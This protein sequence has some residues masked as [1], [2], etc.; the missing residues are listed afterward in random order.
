MPLA[1]Q[2]SMTVLTLLI[3][4]VG[5][6][7]KDRGRMGIRITVHFQSWAKWLVALVL[8]NCVPFWFQQ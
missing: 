7:P 1:M 4:F 8:K 6:F 2:A 5:L 3:S